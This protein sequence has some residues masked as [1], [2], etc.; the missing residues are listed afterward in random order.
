MAIPKPHHPREQLRSILDRTQ[1]SR[2]TK[3]QENIRLKSVA[4]PEPEGRAIL[5]A[6]VVRNNVID[7]TNDA[8]A[9]KRA[10]QS[11][12]TRMPP[13]GHIYV[14]LLDTPGHDVGIVRARGG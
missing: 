3:A 1:D 14:V 5:K 9:T 12:E 11:L 7:L 4:A 6:N 10:T 2:I 13:S 8:S